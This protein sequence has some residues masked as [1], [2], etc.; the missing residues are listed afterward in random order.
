MIMRLSSGLIFLALT[1]AL[2]AQTPDGGALFK[3]HCSTCHDGSA[4]NR[5]PSPDTLH[6]ATPQAILNALLGSMRVPGSRLNSLER[7]AVAEYVTGK[8][9]GG[10]PIGATAD[11]CESNPPFAN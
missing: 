5:A 9:L 2:Q 7:R 10:D 8:T 6:Q 11:R 4:G 1:G 3:D